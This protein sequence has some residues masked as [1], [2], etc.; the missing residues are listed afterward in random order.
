MHTVIFALIVTLL[1]IGIAI[2][3]LIVFGVVVIVADA[4]DLVVAVARL[5]SG[6][7]VRVIIHMSVCLIDMFPSSCCN[8][9][10]HCCVCY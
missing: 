8:H 2:I 6:L 9:C 5:P 7:C 1:A 10:Y 4:V 3:V